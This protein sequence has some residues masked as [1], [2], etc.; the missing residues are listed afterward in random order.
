V[1][2]ERAPATIQL[3]A[4]E[5]M[6]W[7]RDG[8]LVACGTTLATCLAVAE[9]L[10]RRGIDAGVINARFVKP[11]DSATILRAVAECPMS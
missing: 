6:H 2:I 4:A 5:V 11:L 3:G 8:M 1:T 9:E 7:G 10:R